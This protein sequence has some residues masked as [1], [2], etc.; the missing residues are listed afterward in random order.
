MCVL[1]ILQTRV[2][3]QKWNKAGKYGPDCEVFFIL[4][5]HEPVDGEAL[6]GPPFGLFDCVRDSRIKGY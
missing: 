4:M 6:V 2:T 3:S 5:K 1:E